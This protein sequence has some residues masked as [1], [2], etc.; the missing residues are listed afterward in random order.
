MKEKIKTH[1]GLGRF[2]ALPVAACAVLFGMMDRKIKPGDYALVLSVGPG[3]TGGATLL[4][5][6]AR[7]EQ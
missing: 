3:M 4:H 6:G 5:W 1:I 2:F 7:K